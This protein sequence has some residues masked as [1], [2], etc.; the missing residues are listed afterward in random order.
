MNVRINGKKASGI[1]DTGATASCCSPELATR[2]ELET[3][4]DKTPIMQVDTITYPLGIVN[5]KVRVEGQ[6]EQAKL[7]I[8]K[9][10]GWDLLVGL[11]LG[12]KFKLV[13]F[14]ENLKVL[15]APRVT[16]KHLSKLENP[17][18]TPQQNRNTN[19]LLKEH[20]RIFS[21]NE[22]DIGCFPGVTHEIHTTT[23]LAIAIPPYKTRPENE[24]EIERQTNLLLE[25][26]LIRVSRSPWSASVT[27]QGKSDGSKRLCI[28]YRKL[29]SITISNK[30]PMPLILD[31]F[32][33]LRGAKLFTTLDIASGFW[34]V[35]MHENSIAKTGFSTKNGHYE[36]MVMP[37]GLK[38]A[39][40]TF[41]TAVQ[42]IIR[43][44]F[45][46]GIINYA[47]P[48]YTVVKVLR[49]LLKLTRYKD[50]P[51]QNEMENNQ[52]VPIFLERTGNTC[53]SKGF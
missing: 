51:F 11:D 40:A 17:G 24:K 35:R 49:F 37:F 31:I 4:P 5:V 12:R 43:D 32:D 30:A 27:L 7:F 2:L 14:L 39:P 6:E 26:D 10:L 45:K 52:T 21:K 46:D 42:I 28:D 3:F 22:S 48:F 20:E 29:N 34:H 44:W 23:E 1:L 19:H 47:K 15:T 8:I 25:N 33:K 9:N 36:W 16:I 50:Q 38:N 18:L 13:I 41:Q 53:E